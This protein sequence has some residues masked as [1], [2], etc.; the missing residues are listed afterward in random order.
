MTTAV[1]IRMTARTTSVRMEPSVWMKSTAMPA[2]VLGDTGEPLWPHREQLSCLRWDWQG[3]LWGAECWSFRCGS[4]RLNY[5]NMRELNNH[6]EPGLQ[7]C[8][9]KGQEVGSMRKEFAPTL[10]VEKTPPTAPISFNC[11]GLLGTGVTGDCE[12]PCRS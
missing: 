7:T 12:P 9:L 11:L 2:S 10:S 6:L 5:A 1:K 8:L 4:T 3:P